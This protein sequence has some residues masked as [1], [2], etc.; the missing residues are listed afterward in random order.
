MDYDIPDE[1]R[2]PGKGME[3]VTLQSLHPTLG[4]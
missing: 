4:G 2:G 1:P 3:G